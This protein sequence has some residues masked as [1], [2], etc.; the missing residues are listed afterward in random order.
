MPELERPDV[1][2][3]YEVS[4][5]GPPLLM[6]SGFMSDSASWAPLIPLLEPDFTLIRPDNRSTGRTRPWN[7]PASPAIWADDALALLDHLGHRR[8]HVLGH[9]LGGNIA[10][11]LAQDAPSRIASCTMAASAPIRL[12]RNTD[13]FEALIAIRRSDAPSETWL[14]ALFPWLFAPSVYDLPGAIETA[15]AQS[16]G[17]PH[18]QSPEAMAHQLNALKNADPKPFATIPQVPLLALLAERDLLVPLENAQDALKGITQQIIPGT[19]HSVHWDAPD[20]V[21]S[22]LRDFAAKHPIGNDRI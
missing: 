9:S 22:H 14:R 13:L 3:H 19:G 21:A 8:A 17:Y 6:L 16:L 4:G 7:A 15:V 10:W 18:A 11:V 2:L 12:N 5:T 20:A 1:I